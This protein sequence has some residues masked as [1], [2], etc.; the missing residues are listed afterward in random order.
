MV[1]PTPLTVALKVIEIQHPRVRRQAVA[2]PAPVTTV[3]IWAPF[4][5]ADPPLAFTVI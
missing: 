3:A 5:D 1:V 2:A 4:E